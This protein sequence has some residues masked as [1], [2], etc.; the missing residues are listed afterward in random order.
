MGRGFESH[1][2][3]MPVICLN[4]TRESTEYTVPTH[5]AVR[6]KPKLIFFI[7]MQI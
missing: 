6:V 2:S 5:I 3:K 4:R 1:P 7:R